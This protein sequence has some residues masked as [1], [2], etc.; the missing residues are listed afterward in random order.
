MNDFSPLLRAQFFLVSIEVCR[1]WNVRHCIESKLTVQCYTLC[2][3]RSIIR[4]WFIARF[5]TI[6]NLVIYYCFRFSLWMHNRALLLQ[7]INLFSLFFVP[8]INFNGIASARNHNSWIFFFFPKH[9]MAESQFSHFI[10]YF[11]F[12]FF[13]TII[14]INWMLLLVFVLSERC[15]FALKK[16][17]TTKKKKK[18]FNLHANLFQNLSFK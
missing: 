9:T 15:L 3:A 2:W 11:F 18:Q 6:R 10:R 8:Y 5:T 4:R 7:Q 12:F 13:R 1:Q 17:L 14:N 16:K